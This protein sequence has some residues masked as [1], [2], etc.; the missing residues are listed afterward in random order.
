A[1]GDLGE[2]LIEQHIGDIFDVRVEIDLAAS[3]MY[4]LAQARER[5]RPRFVTPRADLACDRREGPASAPSAGHDYDVR[6]I[7]RISVFRAQR[8]TNATRRA[9]GVGSS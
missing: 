3:K 9:Q 4:P 8:Y 6:H 1:Q 7:Q 5:G 2:L